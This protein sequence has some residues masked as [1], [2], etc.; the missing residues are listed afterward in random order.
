MQINSI[1]W[2]IFGILFLGSFFFL[3][4]SRKK[5]KILGIKLNEANEELKKKI[6]T[7]EET[8]KQLK[9][10]IEHMNE[11]IVTVKTDYRILF[12]NRP[13]QQKFSPDREIKDGEMFDV[14]IRNP[15]LNEMLQ[16]IIQTKESEKKVMEVSVSGQRRVVEAQSVYV[17][18][19]S[20]LIVMVFYDLTDIRQSE[21]TKREFITNASHQLK[22]PLTAI[23]GYAETLLEDVDIDVKIRQD[24]LAK[25]KNKSIEASDLVAKL[26]KLSKLESRAREIQI[27]TIDVEKTIREVEKKFEAILKRQNIDVKYDTKIE[28]LQIQTDPNLFELVAENL[29]ENAIKYS[30]P[31]NSIYV[32]VVEEAGNVKV[33]IRDEGIG[34]P[35]QDLPRVFERFFRSHNAETHTHDGIGIGMAMVKSAVESL[36]GEIQVL[37]DQ[38]RGTTISLTFPQRFEVNENV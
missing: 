18:E 33:Q 16:N 7:L 38:G 20:G 34:I 22:T 35:A 29:L 23:Q 13:F 15:Q 4:K 5:N 30:K 32:Q 19:R 2:I 17:P 14:V 37:S 6:H 21:R 12:H 28:G 3:L 31:H 36:N 24:F 26:L 1:I 9:S 11:A 25:I 8:S 27:T 10:V